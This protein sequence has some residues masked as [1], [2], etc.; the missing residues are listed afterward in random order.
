MFNH[1]MYICSSPTVFNHGHP[2]GF[3]GGTS[4]NPGSPINRGG[5]GYNPG[6]S[7]NAEAQDLPAK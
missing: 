1:N 4:Y 3:N 2:G 6:G 5:A 7:F